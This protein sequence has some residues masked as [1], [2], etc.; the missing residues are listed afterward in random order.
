MPDGLPRRIIV[1]CLPGIGDAILFTPALAL[2]RR[3]F[4]QTHITALT[5]FRGSADVLQANLHLDEVRS[6]DFFNA[7][8]VSSLRYVWR[9]R[10][11][12]Y[13]EAHAQLGLSLQAKGDA[14]G[15]RAELRAALRRAPGDAVA[16]RALVTLGGGRP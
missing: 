14:E 1:F 10:R 12:G 11:E 3:A 6:F 5:M 16:A 9:L 2:L 7:G 13:A 15:A 8:V 4:P